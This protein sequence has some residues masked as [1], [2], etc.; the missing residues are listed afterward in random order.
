MPPDADGPEILS[1]RA[2]RLWRELS[3][4]Y[5]E[6]ESVLRSDRTDADLGRL[7]RAI[8][9]AE[10]V[11][12]PLVSEVGALRARLG[13]PSDA[14]AALWAES[15]AL[16]AALARR[17]PALTRAAIAAREGAARA[18]ARLRA[19]RMGATAYR[20]GGRGEPRFASRQA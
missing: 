6:I 5:D 15:D 1:A 3:G 13:A 14:L 4:L 8:V 10:R 2:L 20:G 19:A 18:L 12:R 9:E 7:G 17:Q 11:L 16:V